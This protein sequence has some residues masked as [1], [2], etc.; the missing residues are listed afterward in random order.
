M[1]S[2]ITTIISMSILLLCGCSAIVRGQVVATGRILGTVSDRV[3]A[4]LPGVKV[5][6]TE[7]ETGQMRSVATSEQGEYLFTVLPVGSYRLDAEHAGFN[8]KVIRGIDLRIDQTVSLDMSLDLGDVSNTVEV[9]SASQQL[10]AHLPTLKTEI[11][12][13]RVAELPLEGRNILKLTLLV[14]GVQ[15]TSGAFINQEYTA[16][17][18]IFVSSS[19]G[20]GNTIVYNLD[21]V[22]NSDTYTNVSNSYPNPDAVE[23][24]TIETNSYS[25]EHGRRGGGVV[26]AVTRSGTNEWHG[27]LF[28]FAR[29][30]ALNATNFFTPGVSDGLK[31]HQFGGTLGG[32]IL[33]DKTFFFVSY[34]R[35][36]FRRLSLDSTAIVP[37][38]AM[39]GGDFSNLRL[40]NG[41]LVVIRD[42]N[43]GLP[44]PGNRIPSNRL[45]P[46]AVKLLDF[47]PIPTDPSGLIRLSLPNSSDDDQLV[48]RIDQKLTDSNRLNGRLLY[49]RLASGS[50]IA[51]NDI[52]NS[53][54]R[55]NFKTVNLSIADTHTFSPNLIGIFSATLNRLWSG[56]GADY[57]TTLADLGANIVNLDPR[58]DIWLQV[59][60]FFNINSVGSVTLVRNNY[61]FQGSF[62][63]VKGRH[64]MKFG[65]DVIRQQFNIPAASL[66]SNGL[67]IFGAGY[68]GSNLSDFLLGRPSLFIQVTPWGEALRA[69]QP[70]FYVQDN[71]KVTRR[72][73]LNAGLRFEPY[74][75]WREHQANKI[76]KFL[77]EVQSAISPGLPKGIIIA[78]EAGVPEEAQSKAVAKFAP[79]LG[80][81]YLLPDDKTS[82]R[83]GYGIFFD[84]PNAIINNRFAS[85]IP[86]VVRV[87]VA[88]PTSLQ[89]PWTANQPNPF[90][91]QVPT[92]S[93]F[94]FPRPATAVTYDDNF[95]N[96]YLQQWNL[97]VERQMSANWLARASY[98]GSHGVKLMSLTEINPARFIPGQSTLQN[99]NARRIYAPDFASV[100]SLSS[101][102]NSHYH[103]VAFTVERRFQNDYTLT[104]SYTYGKS[105]DYQSNIV[106]H[107]Q[108]NYT[109]PFDKRYDYALS[110]FD[111][112]HR[113]VSSLIW[114]LPMLSRAQPVVR[115]IAGGW[116]LNSIVTLQSG[117]PFTALSGVD[118]SLDGVGGDRP[119][120]IGDPELSSDRTKGERIA[121]Y[122]N[123][124]AFQQPSLGTFGTVG[125]NTLR[126]PGF[127][128]VDFSAL[129]NFGLPWFTSEGA[130]LQFRAEFYN[131]FNRTNFG[132]PN[133]NLSSPLFGRITSAGEPR[134]IQLALR[135][136]F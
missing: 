108:G 60:G 128:S 120:L 65:A 107:G 94:V 74:L 66:A 95:T 79:R 134:I 133:S 123:I 58:Q 54:V 90:P 80:L 28:E 61:Q 83:G 91:V 118:T 136:A 110:D 51:D 57:P 25:A 70:G 3:G 129:K 115:N 124:S 125:R 30:S 63:Y 114:Q 122:F 15:P 102:G 10:E 19:G 92:P 72:L 20:R 50:G 113:F 117:T 97:T 87:D 48:A 105:T 53:V 103:A 1:G 78:G 42:P 55:A 116:Q 100:Q 99:I 112:R 43:T 69:T 37:T 5:T 44:F 93:G 82:V 9:T 31:R 46:I 126:G 111:T 4:R 130:K 18:Q 39:R 56:K 106:A 26:N 22:D 27:S 67:N 40:A 68:S 62:T 88:N 64:E 127:A 71:F 85:N 13:K 14:P 29:N 119:N 81:A 84:Y 131:L 86:F 76:L 36:T 17:N 77:P 73:A 101:D 109:N 7:V 98:I 2:K 38:A 132:N 135:V 33:K 96:S 121:S 45:D 49:D 89:N 32:P 35:S 21:G 41:Q 59:P 23:A 8:K 47:I 6:V 12:Q 11:D 75:P 34:Q 16:P 52:L 104:S 24:V